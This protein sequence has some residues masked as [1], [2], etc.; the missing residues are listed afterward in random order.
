MGLN[1]W[2]APSIVGKVAYEFNH[3]LAGTAN[4]SNQLLLQFAYGF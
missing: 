1:Y 4:D 3:G 2:F